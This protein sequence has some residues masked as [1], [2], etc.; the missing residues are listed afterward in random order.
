[1]ISTKAD[2]AAV[3]PTT[4]GLGGRG[5]VAGVTEDDIAVAPVPKAFDAL[6]RNVYSSPFVRPVTAADS[7]ADTPSVNVAHVVPE[8]EEYSTT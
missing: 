7:A 3:S 6:T 8:S 1:L 2:S 5:T 4:I